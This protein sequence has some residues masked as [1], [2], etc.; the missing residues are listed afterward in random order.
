MVAAMDSGV[1]VV[2]PV[3]VGGKPQTAHSTSPPAKPTADVQITE[4]TLEDAHLIAAV[5]GQVFSASFGHSVQAEDLAAYLKAEYTAEAFEKE[6]RNPKASTWIARDARDGNALRGFVQ[7]YRGVTDPCLKDAGDV[8]SLAQLHRLYVD[9][10]VHGGGTGS[11]LITRAIDAARAEG[12]RKIWLT[13]WEHNP[14]AERLYSRFGFVR[15]AKTSFCVGNEKQ[16]DW[17]MVKDLQ[18]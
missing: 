8:A 2:E 12:F 18:E 15:V 6:L 5:G 17:V 3:M 10:N 9:T 1:G 13:V 4:A 11:R 16:W 7:L 14:R